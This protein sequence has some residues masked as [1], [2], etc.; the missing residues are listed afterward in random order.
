MRTSWLLGL[1]VWAAVG[2]GGEE[3]V[4][5]DTEDTEP[6][7]PVDADADGFSA[8]EDCDDA[9]A[10]VYPGAEELCDTLDNDCDD[11]V[12]EGYDNDG[13]GYWSKAQ[14]TFGDDCND[15]DGK[16][17]PGAADIPYNGKDE[18]C[19]G[20]DLID[21]DGDTFPATQAG[22]A[23]CDDSTAEVYPGAPEVP[24]DG[25][26]QDC[27]GADLLDADLDGHD[28]VDHGGDDCADADPRINPSRMDWANDAV[29]TDCDNKDGSR[30]DFRLGRA[31][32]TISGT[33]NEQEWLGHR[34]LLCD[35]DGDA[36]D[37][38]VVT[39]P[40]SSSYAGGAGVWLSSYA[41][42]WIEE[43]TLDDADVRFTG[44]GVGFYGMMAACGDI[45]GD[46]RDDLIFGKSEI[47]FTG[48]V[49]Y[50][51]DLTFY[52]YYGDDSWS[53][54][55]DER[56]ADAVWTADLITSPTSGATLYSL[57][58]AVG[59]LNGDKKAEVVLGYPAS[60][61]GNTADRVWMVPGDT[62]AG[63][64]KLDEVVKT[65][66][67]MADPVR[68]GGAGLTL[69][70]CPDL[71]GDTF[72]DLI[73]GQSAW[74]RTVSTAS[75]ATF[76]GRVSF[77]SKVESSGSLESAAYQRLDGD[78]DM[79]L[80]TSVLCADVDGSGAEDLL[81]GAGFASE[82]ASEA[83]GVWWYADP[84]L[85]FS[86]SSALSEAS[87]ALVEPTVDAWL[88]TSMYPVQN[89]VD[90]DGKAEV[91][92]VQRNLKREF[93]TTDDRVFLVAGTRWGAEVDVDNA[94]LASFLAAADNAQT[95]SAAAAGDFSGDGIVDFAIAAP[96]TRIGTG[97]VND[98][99]R[100]YVY[101][102]AHHPWGYIT[103]IPV[104]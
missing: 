103:G 71:N 12:D 104:E 64:K 28:S 66:L 51:Q 53:F 40:L 3:P 86:S 29:D 37:D 25:V 32:Y 14:C 81:V 13:D 17:N 79:S 41:D 68:A 1:G 96:R 54:T 36:V 6:P 75:D 100:V 62:Y 26:D 80:G 2:C 23:D 99:G 85:P 16:I 19:D 10:Q 50:N 48:S 70:V 58:L 39:A 102:S 83:G 30:A 77:F 55:M 91:L 94:R 52:L 59:D 7:P 24:Y 31:L 42:D 57:E 33:E 60:W 18:N 67:D 90:E 61:P 97:T 15:R 69:R 47:Y 65:R 95:G 34:T 72:A 82:F 8:D 92:V 56:K 9:N 73:V 43:M 101:G 45:N 22:G 46:G 35:F 11:T 78:T 63:A 27:S 89:D 21:A 49:R 38:L 4:P 98:A 87:G 93:G 74:Q 20:A 44:S 84:K 76:E 5:V 88:G